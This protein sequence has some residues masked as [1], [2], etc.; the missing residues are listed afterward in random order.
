MTNI[1]KQWNKWRA[2]NPETGADLTGAD[3]SRADLSMADLYGANLSGADLTGADLSR[4][5]LTRAN[6]TGANLYGANLTRADLTGANL[7]GAYLTGANLTGAY[8][9]IRLPVGDPRG[10]DCIAV[11][12]SDQWRI[13]AGCRAYFLDDAKQHW[14]R[15]YQGDRSIGDRYIYGIEYLE[16]QISEGK[17]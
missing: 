6:L 15:N 13:F 14:G 3:L 9:A 2:K 12:H 7:T 10:Y 8:L 16:K 1:V 11:N 4:A 5:D 17:I